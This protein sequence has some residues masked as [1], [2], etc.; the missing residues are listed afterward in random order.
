MKVALLLVLLFAVNV[1]VERA[2]AESRSAK[3]MQNECLVALDLLQGHVEKSFENTLFA[4]E[5]IGYIQGATDTSMA[6]AENVKWY[7]VCVPDNTSTQTIIKKFIAFVDKYPKYDL[8]S[9]SLSMML[10][11]EYPCKK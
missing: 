6:M 3:D 7:K 11:D 8:A 5:C 4:G 2:S 10:A 1:S 9:T